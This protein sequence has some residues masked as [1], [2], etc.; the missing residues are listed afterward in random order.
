[1]SASRRRFLVDT[2]A[3]LAIAGL[4]VNAF[5]QAT[6]QRIRKIA[7]EEAFAT[8]DLV[9]AWLEIARTDPKSSLDVA[10]GIKSIFDNPRPGSNQDRFRRQ[11]LDLDAERL[12]DMDS[13]GVD[14]QLLSVTIPGV[15]M[16]EPG[17]ASTMAIAT[18]SS[19]RTLGTFISTTRAS[20]RYSRRHRPLIARSTSIRGRPPTE[21]LL[22]SPTTVWVAR[23]GDLESRRAR[24]PSG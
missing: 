6:K 22:H 20:H 7:T 15:Q 10:T 11:L 9:K 18:S 8:P 4:S 2:T 13:A 14:V 23:S 17:V 24:T 12:S 1:M 19:I 3:G 5:A 21:W 16:F